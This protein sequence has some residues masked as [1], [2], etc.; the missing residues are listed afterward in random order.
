MFRAL[1]Q[2]FGLA[3]DTPAQAPTATSPVQVAPERRSLAFSGSGGFYQSVVGESFYQDE[4]RTLAAGQSA[5][6]DQGVCTVFLCAETAN[7]HDATAVAVV[8]AAGH[9][10]VGYV[11][12]ERAA[13]Y[14]TFLRD[15]ETTHALGAARRA[16]LTAA[17]RSGRI[18]GSHWTS[19][20]S[21]S[22]KRG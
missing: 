13:Q 11:P 19:C 17:H 8:T 12:R 16:H 10:V 20:R 5:Q 4:L 9:E 22:A 14:W 15:L 1:L 21:P 3:R 2:H 18:T 7:P 6:A